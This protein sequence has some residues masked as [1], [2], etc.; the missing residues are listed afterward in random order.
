MTVERYGENNGKSHSKSTAGDSVPVRVR[1]PAPRRRGRHIVRGD[2]FAKVTSHSFCRGSF[3]NRTHF[4]GLRFGIGCKS[5]SLGIYTVAMFQK[6]RH[7]VCR[8][9]LFGFRRQRR[10]HPSVIEMLGANKLPL[11]R[12][13]ACGKTLVRR[14]SAAPLCG[15]PVSRRYL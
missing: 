15:A 3:P 9:F 4:V 12:G 8:V 14:K 10:L 2:F 1:S 5:G 11:R 6:G 13:F 7:D